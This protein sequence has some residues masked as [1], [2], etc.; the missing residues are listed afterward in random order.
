MTAAERTYGGRAVSD[1]LADRRRRFLDAAL[2]EFSTKGYAASS[3]TSLCK[4]AGLSR[5]Q[6]YELFADREDLLIAIYDEIQGGARLA[7]SEALSDNPSRDLRDLAT[8]AMRAY[9]SSVGTDPRRAEVSFV[10]VVGVSSRVEQ[11]RIDGREEWV[12]FFVA[13]MADVA[14]RPPSDRQRHLAIGFVGALTG[15]VHRWSSSDDPAPL[16]DIVDVLA[17]ILL[18]FTTL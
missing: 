12:D 4:A 13:T 1:R 5:R 9:M 18:A 10:Q 15:L 7:V 14:A 3:V 2:D 8:T 11:H 6:F 16:G 17:D